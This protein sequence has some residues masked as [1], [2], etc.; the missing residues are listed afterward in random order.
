MKNKRKV[1]HLELKEPIDGKVHFYFGSQIAI[2]DTFTPEQLGISYN[3][4]KDRYTLSDQPYENKKCI[5][6]L[7]YLVTRKTNRGVRPQ[8]FFGV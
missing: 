6:R 8:Q 5:I 4:L 1:Y 3:V 2:Y 7:G